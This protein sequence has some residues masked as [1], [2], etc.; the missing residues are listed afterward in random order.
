MQSTLRINTAEDPSNQRLY[1]KIVAEVEFNRVIDT[2]ALGH[3]HMESSRGH[4]R[5]FWS[6]LQIQ[7]WATILIIS[8]YLLWTLN[9]S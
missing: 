1:T 2:E 6:I 3:A 9:T 8:F 7:S 4:G 5:A